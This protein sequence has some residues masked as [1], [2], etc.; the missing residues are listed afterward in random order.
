MIAL[1]A[2]ID[3]QFAASSTSTPGV[4]IQQWR[5]SSKVWIVVNHCQISMRRR[6]KC[7]RVFARGS[8]SFW[9]VLERDLETLFAVN[10]YLASQGIRATTARE[11]VN[12]CARNVDILRCTPTRSLTNIIVSPP[13][14]KQIQ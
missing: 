6:P 9:K 7:L 10:A 11:R 4:V 8:S 12:N 13:P 2:V 3:R 5:G 14:L 1:N